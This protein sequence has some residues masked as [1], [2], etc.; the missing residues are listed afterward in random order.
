MTELARNQ[1]YN[2]IKDAPLAAQ[3]FFETVVE[4][5]KYMSYDMWSALIKQCLKK[6]NECSEREKIEDHNAQF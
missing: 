6:C 2:K 5:F 4:L 3:G 1:F